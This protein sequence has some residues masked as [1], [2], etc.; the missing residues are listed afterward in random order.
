MTQTEQ[1]DYRALY[2]EQNGQMLEAINL[3]KMWKRQCTCYAVLCIAQTLLLAF[4][5][6]A[7]FVNR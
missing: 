3:A 2:H 4:F 7:H 1:I 6:I 5:T